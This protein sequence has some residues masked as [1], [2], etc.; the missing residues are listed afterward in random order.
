MVF[1][2]F[3][4]LLNPNPLQRRQHNRGNLQYR[5]GWEYKKFLEEN[6]KAMEEEL[7]EDEEDCKQAKKEARKKAKKAKKELDMKV[8]EPKA[9]EEW[10][11]QELE[12]D[13]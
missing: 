10:I 5:K 3:K 8:E 1:N 13:Y 12:K 7:K 11:F 4:T 9:K 6:K 2:L